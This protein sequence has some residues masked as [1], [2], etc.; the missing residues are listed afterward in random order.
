MPK[1]NS[2]LDGC[3]NKLFVLKESMTEA[4]EVWENPLHAL[5]FKFHLCVRTYIH[6]WHIHT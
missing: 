3:K 4:I 1:L 6:M 5:N 2:F